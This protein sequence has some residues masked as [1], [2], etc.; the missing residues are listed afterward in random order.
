MYQIYHMSNLG[1]GFVYGEDGDY[2]TVVNP[3]NAREFARMRE[4]KLV[5][6]DCAKRWRIPVERFRIFRKT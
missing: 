5:V 1:S 4:C 6:Q 2:G 3:D